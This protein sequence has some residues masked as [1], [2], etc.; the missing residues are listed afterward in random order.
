LRPPPAGL[1]VVPVASLEKLFE[2]AAFR[3]ATL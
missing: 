1:C 2:L 3:P